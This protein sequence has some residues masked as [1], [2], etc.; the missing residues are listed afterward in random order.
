M[1]IS[2]LERVR[3]DLSEAA[4]LPELLDA[5]VRSLQTRIRAQRVEIVIAQGSASVRRYTNSTASSSD[6]ANPTVISVES[7]NRA[8]VI[9]A[10]AAPLTFNS[11]GVFF[12]GQ[13]IR[14]AGIFH[15]VNPDSEIESSSASSG[16]YPILAKWLRNNGLSSFFVLP[17]YMRGKVAGYLTAQWAKPYHVNQT[18]TEAQSLATLVSLESNRFL[19][20]IAHQPSIRRDFERLID[21]GQLIVLRTDP[22]F[23]VTDLVGNTE[24][25]LGVPR[26]ELTHNPSIWRQLFAESDLRGV[27]SQLRKLN[28]AEEL[29]VEVRL[30]NQINDEPRWLLV[31]GVALLGEDGVLAGWE[32]YG[33]D[34]TDKHLADEGL[35]CER[36]RLSALFQV[37]QAVESLAAPEL[38]CSRG[39]AALAQSTGADA[40]FAAV[41]NA[42]SGRI[43]L[44]ALSGFAES[45]FHALEEALQ[46]KSL[47]RLVLDS[48]DSV[49]VEAIASD[50]RVVATNVMAKAGLQSA[51]LAPLR[52]ETGKAVGALALFSKTV[53]RWNKEEQQVLE[54]AGLLI[55]S[56]LQ[57]SHEVT[58]QRQN[59]EQYQMLYALNHELARLITVSEIG[60]HALKVAMS[61]VPSA[62]AWFALVSQSGDSLVGQFAVG[63]KL[64]RSLVDSRVALNEP[65][66]VELSNWLKQRRITIIA[67]DDSR[68]AVQ[69]IIAALPVLGALAPAVCV[70]V[71]IVTLNQ[72][73]GLIIL[74]PTVPR[75]LVESRFNLLQ[76]LAAEVGTV[77]FARR[78]ESKMSE[79]D[80]MRVTGHLAAGVA[81]NFNNI[82]QGILGH[83]SLLHSKLTEGSMLRASAE[84]ILEAANRGAQ[85][86][87]QLAGL[88]QIQGSVRKTLDLNQFLQQSRGI[89]AS[90][91]GSKISLI[92]EIKA[93]L[94]SVYADESLVQQ[95]IMNLL[96]NAREAINAV[97]LQAEGVVR[98]SAETVTVK[99]GELR[100]GSS[101]GKYVRIS[102]ADNG[103][104]MAQDMAERCFEPFYSTKGVDPRSGL[105]LSGGGLGLSAAYAI[106]REHDGYL[107]V[108]TSVGK[109]STFVMLLPALT[110]SER[111]KSANSGAETRIEKLDTEARDSGSS[112]TKRIY[113]RK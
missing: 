14:V 36:E 71:P 5:A 69:A 37:S 98:L 92:F 68:T 28:L 91:L 29:K 95:V 66:S 93:Q 35:R 13:E 96:M 107:D 31:R 45:E 112:A 73:I 8:A 106:V 48:N 24:V 101:A 67:N 17:L 103:V 19:R 22:N 83:A 82:L 78:L 27:R 50:K 64:T 51:I 62:N 41:T 16:G 46:Q 1:K 2:W 20:T 25:L 55:S 88:A 94:L 65:Q 100:Q 38:V 40:A 18:V 49:S 53:A 52:D 3:R 109:G 32:L 30:V 84:Q 26:E 105:S 33:V 87:K 76:S 9:G 59:T 6:P 86:I 15:A 60:A 75:E 21:V 58:T 89:Y 10:A 104:G 90:A 4:S 99:A 34:I 97:Q 42:D 102:V 110:I 74:Q 63:E 72:V 23:I 54:A 11:K 47:V 79:A 85:L 56:A 108:R 57:R 61:A 7:V 43:E 77:V 39:V 80:K 70:A 81:H 44:V 111:P 12:D 113:G